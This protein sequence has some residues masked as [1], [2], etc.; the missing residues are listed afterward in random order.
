[1]ALGLGLRT[2]GDARGRGRVAHLLPVGFGLFGLGVAVAAFG[3]LA[4]ADVHWPE[5]AGV[6]LV[7]LSYILAG[8][9]RSRRVSGHTVARRCP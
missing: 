6:E 3:V 1:M 2:G 7:G 5:I 8:R 9:S 4:G